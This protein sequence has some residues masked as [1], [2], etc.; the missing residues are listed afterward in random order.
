MS[1]KT[2]IF[3]PKIAEKT[4]VKVSCLPPSKWKKTSGFLHFQTKEFLASKLVLT[5]KS[6]P[7]TWEAYFIKWTTLG[8]PLEGLKSH[9]HLNF[10]SNKQLL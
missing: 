3:C 1:T 6:H 4:E 8:G 10:W 5:L 2:S 7:E 9:W